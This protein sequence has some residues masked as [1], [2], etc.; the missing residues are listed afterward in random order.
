A[1]TS[2][3]YNHF[4]NSQLKIGS[5]ANEA[6]GYAFDLDGVA[7]KD[8]SLGGVLAGLNGT[9]MIDAAIQ[10]ALTA[11]DFVILHSVRADS[12][13]SDTTVSWQIWLG[14]Q[15]AMPKYDGTGTFTVATNAPHDAIINGTIT[16]GK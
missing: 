2:G 13:T 3:T 12:L 15:Q 7:G 16:D 1:C 14:A 9:L 6:N 5:S 8:N 4:P 10:S 11:G